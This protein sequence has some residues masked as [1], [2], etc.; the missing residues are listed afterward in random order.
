MAKMS[1]L[2]PRRPAFP[3][4]KLVAAALALT[5]NSLPTGALPATSSC[6]NLGCK[7]HPFAVN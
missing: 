4:S 1:S 6:Q 5:A 3:V 7:G 2:G